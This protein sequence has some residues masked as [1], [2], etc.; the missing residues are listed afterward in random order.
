MRKIILTA[1]ITLSSL[2]TF[3]QD[4]TIAIYK[5][6]ILVYDSEKDEYE[7]YKTS[8]PEDMY[9]KKFGNMF[10]INNQED[11][12]YRLDKK[13]NSESENCINYLATDKD[14]TT[15]GLQFC[16]EEDKKKGT[17]TALYLNKRAVVYHIKQ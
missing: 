11:S 17:V 1:L 16:L 14:D 6:N 13:I 10:V 4:F 5:V 15:I 2:Y 3:A 12:N 9:L 7:L 8:Y